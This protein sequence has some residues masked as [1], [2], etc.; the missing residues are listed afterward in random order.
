ALDAG[1]HVFCEWPLGRNVEEAREMAELAR[2]RGVVTGIGLQGHQDP[3]LAYVKDLHDHGWLGHMLSVNMT[4]LTGGAGRSHSSTAWMGDVKNGANLMTIV[5]GHCLDIVAYCF[6]PLSE[7]AA[8]VAT[9]V[10][11]WRLTDTDETIHVDAPD[12]VA[13][14]AELVGGGVLSFHVASVPFNGGGWRM[15][16]HGTLGSLVATTPGLPQITPIALAGAQGEQPLGPLSVPERL[17]SAP[18]RGAKGPTR[19]VASAYARMSDAIR[20]GDP[21]IPDFEHAVGLHELLDV[22]EESSRSG[23]TVQIGTPRT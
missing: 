2:S 19:N 10:P 6:G 9:T 21:F 3:T 12:T 11:A 23:R 14:T 4:M 5:A 8:S 22:I 20:R 1:K 17:L 16:A 18:V 7:V 13:L 15:A